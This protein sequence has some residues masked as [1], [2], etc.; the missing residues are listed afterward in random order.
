MK[1]IDCLCHMPHFMLLVF[2]N[3][4]FYLNLLCK[5]PF[6]KDKFIPASI[7]ILNLPII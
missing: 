1:F 4:W 5:K 6:I 2:I 3:E 7:G